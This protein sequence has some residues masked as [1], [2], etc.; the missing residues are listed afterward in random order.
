MTSTIQEKTK[1]STPTS[2]VADRAREVAEELIN[3]CK[4]L[5]DVATDEE[6]SDKEF[7]SVLDDECFLCEVCDWWGR[8][9]EDQAYDHIC[10]ECA[11]EG[12]GQ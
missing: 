12:H 5:C 11:E 3:T 8:A 2:S 9:F 4:S 1:S 7:C 6:I 10:N